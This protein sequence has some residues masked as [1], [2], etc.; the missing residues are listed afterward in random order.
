MDPLSVT[1]SIIAILQLSAKVLAYLNDV[2]DASKDCTQCVVEI[3]NL[4]GVLFNL[5]D[6]V[7]WGDHTKPW[8]TAVQAIATKNGTFDQ[9][10]EA[11][12]TLQ[13]KI[14]DGGRQGRAGDALLWKFRKEEIASILGRMERLKSLVEIALQMDHL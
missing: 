8:Y 12:E 6:R 7:E 2:R 1:A 11:L 14:T 10:K 13:T 9:F 5:K 4:R 3:L